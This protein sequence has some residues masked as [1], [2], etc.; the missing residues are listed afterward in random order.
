MAPR[1]FGA[2]EI[3]DIH[4]KYLLTQF[5]VSLLFSSWSKLP[6]RLRTPLHQEAYNSTGL[7][8]RGFIRGCPVLSENEAS[9][10]RRISGSNRC[11]FIE[12]ESAFRRW[13]E[14]TAEAVEER[15]RMFRFLNIAPNPR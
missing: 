6:P 10:V 13:D 11:D 15:E 7:G 12:F 2:E 5:Q 9:V 1:C 8:G 4:F 14:C 3:A